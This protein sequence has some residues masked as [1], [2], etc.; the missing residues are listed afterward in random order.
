MVTS[1]AVIEVSQCRETLLRDALAALCAE[2]ALA[3]PW[4]SVL[5]LREADEQ[6]AFAARDFARAVD[7]LPAER[8]PKGWAT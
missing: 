3:S 1:P 4:S 2:R 7:A 6:L 8:Q 5:T